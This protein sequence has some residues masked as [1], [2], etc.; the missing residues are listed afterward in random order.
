MM[1]IFLNSGDTSIWVL[2]IFTIDR[3][4]A[5]CFPLHKHECWLPTRAKYYALGAFLLAVTKNFAVFWT[6]GAEYRPVNDTVT[7]LV[8]NCGRPTAAYKY[9]NA[10][11]HPLFTL[12]CSQQEC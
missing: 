1:M 9:A 7:V 10:A 4:S 8:D 5:I 11:Y 12:I 2:V 3:F 6:R